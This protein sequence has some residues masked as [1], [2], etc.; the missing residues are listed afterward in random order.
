MKLKAPPHLEEA[1]WL[2][3]IGFFVMVWMWIIL[4]FD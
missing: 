1:G 3:L 2:L 4:A